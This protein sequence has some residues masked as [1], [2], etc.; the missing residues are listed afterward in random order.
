MILTDFSIEIPKGWTGLTDPA[1]GKPLN[2]SQ[3]ELELLRKVQMQELPEEGFEQYPEYVPWFTHEEEKMPIS[4]APEPKRRFLPSKHEQQ[5]IMKIVRAIR[6]GRIQPYVPPEEREQE[7]D[8]E[9][10][11]YD[12]WA[13]EQ[14]QPPHVMHIPPPKQPPPGFDLSYKYVILLT[15]SAS[16]CA[17]NNHRQPSP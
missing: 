15:L 17:T 12:L 13:N 14:A 6:E 7:E 10:E 5:R 11:M 4:A 1:T 9:E 16:L 2:L 3:K 8:E